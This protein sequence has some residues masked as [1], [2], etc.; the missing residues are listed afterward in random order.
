M[1]FVRGILALFKAFTGSGLVGAFERAHE[2][3]LKA[4]N[5]TDRLAADLDIKRIGSALEMAQIRAADRW[6]ASSLGCYLIVV[7][8]GLWWAAIFA[9]Q[10]VNP[11][12]GWN[13]VVID[14]PPRIHDMASILIPAILIGDVGKSFSRMIRR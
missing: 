7:P 2:R 8:Y 13:L 3:K 10:I 14:V 5:D 11:W 9:V 4:Q 12:L 6:G 1:I